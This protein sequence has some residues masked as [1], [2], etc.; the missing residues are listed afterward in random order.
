MD[1]FSALYVFSLILGGVFVALSV[2]S[3]LGKDVEV[4]KELELDADADFDADLDADADFDADLD[5]DADFDADA[6]FDA[7]VDADADFDADADADMEVDKSIDKDIETG[8]SRKYRPY[9]SF[10]F[11][12][13]FLAFFGLNGTIFTFLKLLENPL[14]TLGISTILGLVAGLSVSYLLHTANKSS[15]GK[16]I[17]DSDFR[18]ATAQV[19][20]PFHAGRRGK[21]Q[22]VS[23][24]RLI[25][26]EAVSFDDDDDEVVFDF[27]DEC[28]IIEVEDGIAKVAHTTKGR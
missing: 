20:L 9:T 11:W 7:D 17:G 21:V 10:K 23:K 26:L 15:G 8:N 22:V 13:F 18:H 6:H 28:V 14:V 27:D 19:V 4:D 24:G 1:M 16:T 2:F 25:E 3:G 12:T 5:A